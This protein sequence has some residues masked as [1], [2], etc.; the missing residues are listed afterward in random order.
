VCFYNP[1][2][3]VGYRYKYADPSQPNPDYKPSYT[4]EI[5][6]WEDCSVRCGGGTQLGE[7]SCIEA[8]MGKV[9][10]KLCKD[11]E[12]PTSQTRAC[13]EL[14]CPVKWR[15]GKWGKCMACKKQSGVRV[16]EVECIRETSAPNGDDVLL[17]NDQCPS[18]KPPT[19]ELCDSGKVCVGKKRS[20]LEIPSEMLRELW[21]QTIVDMINGN[22]AVNIRLV[23]IRDSFTPLLFHRYE[24]MSS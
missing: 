16:R 13:N 19:R 14:P 6:N 4:W 5:V 15:I 8:K 24:T 23:K 17:E 21:Y 22:P 7:P 18:P 11:L 3:N 10:P 20:H 12:K 1:T 9:S 2:E